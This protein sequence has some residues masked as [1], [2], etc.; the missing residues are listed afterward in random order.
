[1]SI[2]RDTM[3]SSL[4]EIVIPVLRH[5]GFKGSFPHFRKIDKEKIEL[6]TFQFD[7]YGGGFVIEI[8][9]CS[10]EGFTCS[11]GE[12]KP[13][14]K[15]TAHDLHPDN[16]MR[17]NNGNWFRYDDSRPGDNIYV[18]VASDVINHFSEADRYWEKTAPFTK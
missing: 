8:A 2:E 3:I 14:N 16:R 4:K 6:L 10:S 7:K 9:V 5:K 18:R 17:L 1:M 11:W 13:P 12:K 15:V